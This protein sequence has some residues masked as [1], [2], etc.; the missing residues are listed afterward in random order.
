MCNGVQ[1]ETALA[2]PLGKVMGYG[3]GYQPDAAVLRERKIG[4]DVINR[5]PRQ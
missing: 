3:D 2:M 4:L 5:N 1:D